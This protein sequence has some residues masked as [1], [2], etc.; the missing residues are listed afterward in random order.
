MFACEHRQ[1]QQ[2]PAGAEQPLG[3]EHTDPFR[4]QLD[5][6][7]AQ[8]AAQQVAQ[9]VA[10]QAAQQAAAAQLYLQQQQ[11]HRLLHRNHTSNPRDPRLPFT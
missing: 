2:Q 4:T 9:Q 11:Q 6:I 10:Q 1:Q 3:A 7:A 5:A 8:Q